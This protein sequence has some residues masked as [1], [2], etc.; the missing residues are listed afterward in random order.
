M[1]VCISLYN[2]YSNKRK[3]IFVLQYEELIKQ[4]KEWHKHSEQLKTSS[5]NTPE[6]RRD[7]SQMEEEK[8]QLLK[9]I[10]RLKRKVSRGLY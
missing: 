1:C 10:E 9:R 5:F 7:I 2:T 6:I 4:F 3:N 8:E